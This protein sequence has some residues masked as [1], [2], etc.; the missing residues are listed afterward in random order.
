[1][2]K[3]LTIVIVGTVACVIQVTRGDLLFDHAT[4]AEQDLEC[5]Y[6][7]ATVVP[8]PDW[9]APMPDRDVCLDCHDDDELPPLPAYPA[10][11]KEN[12]RYQHQF[13]ARADGGDCALCHR[14]SEKCTVCHHGENVD[15]IVHDRNWAFHHPLTFYK[16]TEECTVCH[17]PRGFCQDCHLEYGVRPGNHFYTQWPSPAFH[18]EEAKIDLTTCI[19]CHDGP[20]PVCTD[21]HGSLE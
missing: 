2:K 16:G 10:T 21:C 14:N 19:Q 6:C 8:G 3:L 20:D 5:G 18:G 11:H 12:Y 7:H 1:M 17:E 9:E 4:H 15:F 13:D